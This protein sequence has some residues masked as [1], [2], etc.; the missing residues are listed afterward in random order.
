MIV[1]TFELSKK[2]NLNNSI[3]LLY[4][5][6]E[7][8]KN[9]IIE[10]YFIEGFKGNIERYEENEILNN[11]D[12]ISS[13]M[14]K[15]LFDN[16]K[17]III[18]RLSDKILKII[19]IILEKK[20][21]GIKLILNSK[22]LDKKSKLRNFFEKS[23]GLVCI[24]FYEDDKKTLIS[25]ANSFFQSKK[26]LISY[27]A[28]NALIDKCNGDRKNLYNE[29]N[30]LSLYVG[31]RKKINIEDV[32]ILTNLSENFSI[33]E[34]IDNCLTKNSSRTAKILNENNF[35]T[36]DSIMIIRSLLSK[37][38]RIL[39]LKKD[40]PNSSSLE[41]NIS[42]YK[43]PIF[44]KEKDIVKKQLQKWSIDETEKLIFKI[45]DIELFAKKNQE[46]SINIV[47]DF[48]LDTS[49]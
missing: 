47:S 48:I 27:E 18:S 39:S 11:D 29:L 32:N 14:N 1:K 33:S 35:S 8:F 26:I 23:K 16:E 46:N 7:G 6:N 13:L 36:D 20:I 19:E 21:S 2:E 4:G 42:A 10:R 24:P 34:L 15:S 3:F 28:I 30:K 25:L 49:R 38:K 41:Q 5:V 12:F 40:F 44:W 37:S 9:Q 17:L 45:S 43:P 22:S 31:E